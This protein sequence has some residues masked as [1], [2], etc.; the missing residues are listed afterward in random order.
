[1][2]RMLSP[3]LFSMYI[4]EIIN[5]WQNQD[6]NGIQLLRNKNISTILFADQ[7]IMSDSIDNLQTA[8]YKLNKIITEYG[9]TITTDKSKLI[10]FKA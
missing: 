4:Y 3:A 8:I 9:L 7:V 6:L 5:I 10:A 2:P 1:M